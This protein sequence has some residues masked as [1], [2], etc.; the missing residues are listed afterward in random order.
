MILKVSG[1]SNQPMIAYL[2]CFGAS[3]AV[4]VVVETHRKPS[5][6][7][8]SQESKLS[9][10]GLRSHSSLCKHSLSEVKSFQ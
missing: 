2:Y 7:S 4:H 6:L 8:L 5:C 10:Q 1:L 9:E 3:A